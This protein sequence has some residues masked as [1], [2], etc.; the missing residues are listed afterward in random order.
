[1]LIF[2]SLKTFFVHGKKLQGLAFHHV[3][4]LKMSLCSLEAHGPPGQPGHPGEK[5][6]KGEPGMLDPNEIIIFGPKGAKGQQGGKGASGC[7]GP[8]GIQDLLH[9]TIL[10]L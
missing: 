2:L 7:P 1:M 4:F 10:H 3:N 6:Q 8:Q 9:T 5:G